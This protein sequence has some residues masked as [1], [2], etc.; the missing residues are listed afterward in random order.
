MSLIKVRQADATLSMAATLA[1]DNGTTTV[2]FLDGG[3][4][5]VTADDTG[6][7]HLSLGVVTDLLCAERPFE[8]V[9]RRR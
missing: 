4:T 1:G 8:F 2:D 9:A 7:L 3:T 5:L 6:L